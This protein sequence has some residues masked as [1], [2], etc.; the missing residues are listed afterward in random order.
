MAL[1]PGQNMCSLSGLNAY[2][3]DCEMFAFQGPLNWKRKCFCRSRTLYG[4]TLT[5]VRATV[6]GSKSHWDD[7]AGSNMAAGLGKA[8]FELKI[9]V[10]STTRVVQHCSFS[11]LEGLP[12]TDHFLLYIAY[13]NLF[14]L[15]IIATLCDGY[16]CCSHFTDK[17]LRLRMVSPGL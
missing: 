6:R 13:T 2:T 15:L 10:P 9:L 12:S 11:A 3:A 16:C 8:P 4:E 1:H 14:S 7:T 5:V 17:K